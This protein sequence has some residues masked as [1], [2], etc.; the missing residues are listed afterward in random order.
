MT[1]EPLRVCIVGPLPPP[2][3]GMANQTRQLAELL[4]NEGFRVAV[5]QT[6][7][8]YRP[9][10]VRH[11]RGL[12]AGFRLVPYALR[13]WSQ[14]RDAD[15]VHLMANSGWSWFYFAVP[16]AVIARLRAVP[17]IVNY[18]G[19]EAAPFLERSAWAVRPIVRRAAALV[20]PS[21]FLQQVFD[22][23]GM[24]A[25]IVPNIVDLGRFRPTPARA[26]PGVHLVVT[27]NLEPIYDNATAIRALALIRQEVPEARLT[28][29][30][31]GPL[32]ASLKR[33]AAELGVDDVVVFCGRVANV[34]M[35]RLYASADVC[36]NP[37]LADNM[38]I[39][40]LE[41]LASGVPVVSTNVG[42]VPYL[43][44]HERTALLVEPGD[45]AAM[46]QA[47][48]RLLRDAA[49]NARLR[50]AGLEKVRGFDWA[51]VRPNLLATYAVATDRAVDVRAGV[52]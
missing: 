39:S 45:P 28:I 6:N 13:L 8:G 41:S 18:R 44:E 25:T 5:V 9:S 29:A 32:L 35:P 16:A 51:S 38:P 3:G 34:E 26:A 20:V 17:L 33:L 47:V 4:G 42:G 37:S 30:G 50:T 49:L 11:L 27:R 46:A 12:R 21:G 43:V 31:E 24:S 52:A 40:L 15:L 22:R 10:W 7:A 48:L 19:G 1:A 36:L 23:F 14:L 2:S